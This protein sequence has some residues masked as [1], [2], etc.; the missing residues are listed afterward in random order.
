MIEQ[1]YETTSSRAYDVYSNVGC[2]DDELQH[3]TLSRIFKENDT[4]YVT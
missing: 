3:P 2:R 1:K 4:N